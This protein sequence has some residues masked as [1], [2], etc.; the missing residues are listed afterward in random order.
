[1][2]TNTMIGSV[3]ETKPETDTRGSHIY[4][5]DFLLD[6]AYGLF[7][8]NV[9]KIKLISPK[10]KDEN[11][12]TYVMNF[13]EVCGSMNRDSEDLRNFISKELQ[14]DTSIK[15]SGC[16]KIDGRLKNLKMIE[17]LVRNFVLE[18]VMC[19]TCRSCKTRT[20]KVKRTTYLLCD[21][22][23]CKLAI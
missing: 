13:L 18:H 9:G 14:M 22:C 8:I 21:A 3:T 23:G 1:M 16:L 7:T 4:D 19:K 17:R 6:R 2:V 11:K 20:E 15:E 5:V 10:C 12:K